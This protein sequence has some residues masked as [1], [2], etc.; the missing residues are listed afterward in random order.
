MFSMLKKFKS[1]AR[2]VNIRPPRERRRTLKE[3][4]LGV[5][6]DLK[7]NFLILAEGV[8][9]IKIARQIKMIIP[10]TSKAIEKE[11]KDSPPVPRLEKNTIG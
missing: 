1:S 8:F 7:D 2:F 6:G 4:I 9:L 11:E 5:G 3:P 10:T